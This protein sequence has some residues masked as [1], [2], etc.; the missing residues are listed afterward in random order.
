M[1]PTLIERTLLNPLSCKKLTSKHTWSQSSPKLPGQ[2]WELNPGPYTS[3]HSSLPHTVLNHK[4]RAKY[5]Y[6]SIWWFSW[7]QTTGKTALFRQPDVSLKLYGCTFIVLSFFLQGHSIQ[8]PRRVWLSNMYWKFGHRWS[9]NNLPREHFY[10]GSKSAK[11]GVIFNVTELW[12]TGVWKC[13]KISQ[14]WNKLVTWPSSLCVF[15]KF[16]EVRSMH[17][18]EQS[19][20]SAPPPR[21]GRQKCAKWSITLPCIVRFLSNFVQSL[22]TWRPKYYKSSRSRGQRSRS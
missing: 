5:R 9:S 18:G 17:L 15:S 6:S 12:G 16:G 22:D 3:N 13:S 10:R 11:F 4:D 19:G 1:T 21:T 8:Q 14:L 7:F 20:E 2:P